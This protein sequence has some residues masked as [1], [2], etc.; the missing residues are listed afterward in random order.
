MYEPHAHLPLPPRDT[1]I[2]RYMDFAKF[3]SMLETGSLFFSRAIN[4]PDQW[5]CTWSQTLIDSFKEALSKRF[6]D[7]AAR[8]ERL[9]A[10][11]ARDQICV[12]C[13]NLNPHES[14]GMWSLYGGTPGSLAV[15]S[16][17]GRLVD[18]LI[19]PRRVFVGP[20]RYE[21]PDPINLPNL[22][23]AACTKRKV[24]QD[25]RELRAMIWLA[26]FTDPSKYRGSGE[27]VAVNLE[28][29]ISFVVLAP[30]A[31]EWIV[32][33][34]KALLLRYELKSVPCTQSVL[35]EGPN[36]GFSDASQ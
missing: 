33:L 1:T 10:L 3:V 20:V 17:V 34:T 14:Q 15:Q 29:L 12:N 28:T 27:L 26:D 13:W 23:D 31:P 16:T 19:A 7:P 35:D 6:K 5:E 8:E 18:S 9:R 24:F 30:L 22:F 4:L 32:Q 36:L 11:M 21:D 25:E 2:W